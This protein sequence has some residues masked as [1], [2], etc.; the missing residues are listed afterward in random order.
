MI[1]LFDYMLNETPDH[2]REAIAAGANVNAT[3]GRYKGTVLMN[4]I[5]TCGSPE[6]IKILIEAGAD[7]NAV[8]KGGWSALS[9]YYQGLYKSDVVVDFLQEAGAKRMRGPIIP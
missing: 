3:R 6:I 8:N 4:A 5:M 1:N 7:V 9:I 2:V